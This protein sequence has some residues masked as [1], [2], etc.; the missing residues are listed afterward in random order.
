MYVVCVT[1]KVKPEFIEDFKEAIRLN[2]EGTRQEPNNL[3]F[4]VLQGDDDAGRF[5]LYEVYRTKEDF[6]Y[7]QTTEHF[8]KWRSSVADM[9]Q[10]PRVR[11]SY[12]SVFP[13]DESDDY[14]A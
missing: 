3:R 11:A 12:N 9:M 2:H 13:S 4:D 6:A 1:I 10:E 14:W 8:A 7:H 5:F